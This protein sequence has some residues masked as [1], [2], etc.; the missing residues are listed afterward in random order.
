[1]LIKNSL[2]ILDAWST[3]K[4]KMRADIREWLEEI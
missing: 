1:M 4:Q 3:M 2:Q